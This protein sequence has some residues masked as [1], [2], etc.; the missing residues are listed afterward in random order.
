MVANTLREHLGVGSVESGFVLPDG[1]SLAD[2]GV[3]IHV[4]RILWDHLV[5]QELALTGTV[6][7]GR[8]HAEEPTH[9]GFRIRVIGSGGDDGVS[10]PFVDIGLQR[11]LDGTRGRVFPGIYLCSIEISVGSVGKERAEVKSAPLV[12][13][14]VAAVIHAGNAGTGGDHHVIEIV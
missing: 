11:R 5:D 12:Q 13:R 14:L 8:S 10:G 4:R 1:F 2:S 7:Y 6:V 9:V 3:T